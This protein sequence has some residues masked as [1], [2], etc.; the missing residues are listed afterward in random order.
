VLASHG[1]V[2]I[3]TPMLQLIHGG[4]TARPFRTHLNAF[5]Q[6]MTLR[7]AT[8][9]YLKKAVVG[10]IERVFEIGKV[11]RNEGVDSSHSPEFTTLEAYEAYGDQYT[12]AQRIQEIILACADALGVDTIE[13][14]RGTIDLRGEWRWLSVYPGLSEAVGERITPDTPVDV[15]RRVAERHEVPVDPFWDAETLVLELFGEIVEPTLIQPTFVCD[16]PPSAQPLARPHRSQDGVIEA[17]D[18]I[19]G[20]MERGTAFSELIDPVV[21]RERLTEQSRRAA[22]GDEEAMQLDE[23]F[24]RALEH[25][26]PPMGGLGLG[27]DRLI[28]LFTDLGIRET[29][30]FPLMK[31]EQD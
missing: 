25:G 31:P 30:L 8:E 19:I 20:V 4:A 27:L 14:E 23:D 12:M 28:M 29:I 6:D 2:E 15:L 9:L 26:A 13:S 3:E 16:Y 7:I 5:D 10:G 18:L 11:F 22:A 24:L 1:Y 21:Q 17:W